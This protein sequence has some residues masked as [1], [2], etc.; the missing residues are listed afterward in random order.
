MARDYKHT[1]PRGNS[2]LSASGGFIIGLLIGLTIAVAIYMYDHRPG[3]QNT[4]ASAPITNEKST[5]SKEAPAPESAQADPSYDFYDVLPNMEV[6]VSK[7]KSKSDNKTPNSGAIEAPGSYILQV[8]SY[9][10]FQD[11]DRVRAQIALHGIESKIQKVTMDND[12]WHR[13]RIGP[14]NNLAKLEDTRRKLREAQ[15]D[16]LVI[17]QEDSQ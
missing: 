4:S 1:H 16:A 7:D 3:A 14:M 9:R 13:V 10:N 12:T 15:I 5:N 11:A 8:G 17:R 6:E 2:G